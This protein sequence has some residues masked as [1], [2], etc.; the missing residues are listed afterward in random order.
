MQ[1]ILVGLTQHQLAMLIGVSYQQQHKYE[2]GTDRITAGRLYAIGRAL[3]VDV[4]DF[5]VGLKGRASHDQDD[6]TLGLSRAFL[7]ICDKRHQQA[8]CLLARVLADEAEE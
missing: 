5:F 4:A 6:L 7:A 2:R 8:V 3:E 1:R